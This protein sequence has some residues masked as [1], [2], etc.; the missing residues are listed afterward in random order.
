VNRKIPLVLLAFL[1]TS[2]ACGRMAAQPVTSIP[3]VD[4]AQN[5]TP[6]HSTPIRSTETLV[7]LPLLWTPSVYAEPSSV[8]IFTAD[9]AGKVDA[10]VTYCIAEDV[11]LKM[12]MYY[13]RLPATQKYPAIIYIHGGQF[14]RG[15]KLQVGGEDPSLDGKAFRDSGYV[16]I[17]LNYRL[18]PKYKLPAM[19]EDVKCALRHLHAR[20]DSYN[21]DP[22]RMGV[23]G[24]SSGSTLAAIIGLTDSSAGFDGVGAYQ[25]FSSRVQAV[26]LQYPQ[27]A[28]D[29]PP[30]SN[31]EQ[32]S[33]DQT[34]PPDPSAEFLTRLNLS[35]YVS[36]GDPPF[37]ILHGDADPALN[38]QLSEQL[39]AELVAAGVTSSF[40]L[41]QNGGHG[42]R[43]GDA[44]KAGVPYRPIPSAEEILNQELEFFDT[45]LQ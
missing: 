22:D 19:Y 39:N 26:V 38:P 11:E 8:P 3:T 33:R 17:S 18:G 6:T 16:F 36:A 27:V 15:D 7:P 5:P 21:I 43:P 35:T 10:N 41:V 29:T 1:I 20:A 34:L 40:I 2:L 30:Y 32:A 45:Y 44:R 13:P 25:D 24:N 31:A 37:L 14:I 4:T 9:K 28:F 12:D 42:W 23:I